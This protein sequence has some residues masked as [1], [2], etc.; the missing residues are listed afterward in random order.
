MKL[1]TALLAAAPVLGGVL[2]IINHEAHDIIHSIDHIL[3]PDSPY[4]EVHHD[5]YDLKTDR[6]GKLCV[7]H[8]VEEGFDDENFKKAVE[9]CGDGGIVR[10]PDAN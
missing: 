9:V 8:P 7:L 6:L 5:H 3:H 4:L 1:L 10:L 2:D